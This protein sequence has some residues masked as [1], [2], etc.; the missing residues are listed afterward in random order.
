MLVLGEQPAGEA[1]TQAL[2][3]SL[4]AGDE[5]VGELEPTTEER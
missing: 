2:D 3:D 1:S 4:E 5:I